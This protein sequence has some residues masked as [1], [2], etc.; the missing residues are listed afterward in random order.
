MPVK[1]DF[2]KAVGDHRF[3]VQLPDRG[4]GA[5]KEKEEFRLFSGSLDFLV[6]RVFI[7]Y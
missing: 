2:I 7:G 1:E 3:P 5:D 4:K 6:E